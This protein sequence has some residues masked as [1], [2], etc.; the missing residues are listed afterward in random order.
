MIEAGW[1]GLRIAAIPLDAPAVQLDEMRNAFFAGA[2][3]LFYSIMT[4]LE[5]GSDAT[6][7][8]L[9]RMDL[10]DRELRAFINEYTVRNVPPEGNA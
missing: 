10:I 8:D 7:N 6:D 2:Q 3:H 4:I 5:E 1:I 9:K